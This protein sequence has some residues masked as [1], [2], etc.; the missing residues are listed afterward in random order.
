[1][2]LPQ[3]YFSKNE[4]KVCRLV[5]SLYGLKQAPRQWNEKLTQAL[6]ENNFVQSVSDYSLFVKSENDIFV[7]LLVYVDDIVITGN[8]EFEIEKFKTFLKTKFLIKDLGE[9]KYFLGIEVLKCEQGVCLSQR[10]YCIE[11][12]NEFGLL[13]SKPVAVPMDFN[14]K[15]N[16]EPNSNDALLSNVTKYQK[17]VG[18]L[19]YL[20]NTRPDIAF[21]VQCLSRYMHSPLSSH[22]KLALRILRYL[23]GSPG[24]GVL[25]SR[26]ASI[27]LSAYVDAD[28]GK[29]LQ[30]RKSITGY[31]VFFCG[32]LVSWKSKQQA[33]VS[34]SS[35]ESEYRAMAA[36]TAEI[37][38][39]IN[40]LTDLK[41]NNLLPVN[42]YCDNRSAIQ[43]AANPVFHER[44]K[45][46][47]IDLHLVRDKCSTGAIRIVNV[48]SASQLADIFTKG[49]GVNSHKFIC[50]ELK[51]IDLFQKLD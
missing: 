22:L 11:L 10:K 47:E 39:I 6:K 16:T 44:T 3:G 14:V 7:A 40:I 1:M 51:L 34:R 33:A 27:S 24:K 2:D 20:T 48:Q 29:C 23:K 35:T 30:S 50:D 8:N 38:W 45:H 42:L 12:I 18:K 5:K 28:W 26:S 32:S 4:T 37:L 25:L 21:A 49:L 17:L 36:T 9:L 13:G 31:C 19:I 41:V 43:I 46:F 15:L